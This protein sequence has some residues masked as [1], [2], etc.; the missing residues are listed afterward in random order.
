MRWSM[1]SQSHLKKCIYI[2]DDR[3][4]PLFNMVNFHHRGLRPHHRVRVPADFLT[5]RGDRTKLV[6]KCPVTEKNVGEMGFDAVPF[7]IC[8]PPSTTR[9]WNSCSPHTEAK[10]YTQKR[11]SVD[12]K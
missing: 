4:R 7:T 9:I 11:N 10:F 2:C 12:E 6:I 5:L 8:R 3:V 1:V